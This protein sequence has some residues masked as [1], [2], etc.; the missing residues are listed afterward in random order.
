[1]DKKE[2][3]LKEIAD[4]EEKFERNKFRRMMY[5]I[6]GITIFSFYIIFCNYK[7]SSIFDFIIVLVS[8]IFC[9]FVFFYFNCIT[10]LP[11]VNK[12]TEENRIIENLRKQYE[13]LEKN[14]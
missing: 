2:Q 4:K 9:A 11:V 12:A 7:I 10:F 5:Y 3:L 13:D 1:M 6:G 8:S 14:I